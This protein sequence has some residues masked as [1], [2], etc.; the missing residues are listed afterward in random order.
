M[1]KRAT[2]L[3][4]YFYLK[5]LLALQSHLE[6]EGLVKFAPSVGE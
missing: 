5:G 2:L 3:C 1:A 4:P 6:D